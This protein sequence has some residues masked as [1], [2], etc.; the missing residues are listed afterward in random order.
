V[1]LVFLST[2]MALLPREGLS[3]EG[4]NDSLGIGRKI[5]LLTYNIWGLPGILLQKPKR[6]KLLESALPTEN[7]DVIILNETF[8]ARTRPVVMLKEFPYRAFGPGKSGIKISSGVVILSKFP[9]VESEAIKYSACAG[10]DCLSNKGAVRARL[11]LPGVGPVDVVGTH[12]NA[13]GK[14]SVRSAQLEEVFDMLDRAEGD[15][16]V[17]FGGDFNF[18]SESGPYY[19]MAGGMGF[20]DLHAE[21]RATHPEMDS[22]SW[23]GFTYDPDRNLNLLWQAPWSKSERLDYIWAR[24]GACTGVSVERTTLLMD[25]PVGGLHLSDHFGVKAD[26]RLQGVADAASCR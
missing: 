16:P 2:V 20:R 25:H 21:Y 12:M 22:V 11:E 4:L 7:A 19:D 5:R 3:A 9:I 15:V 17:L 24:D 23:F 10:T 26:L 8:A 14:D 18:H 13:E 1:L 6:M